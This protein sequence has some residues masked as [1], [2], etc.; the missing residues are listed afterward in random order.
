MFTDQLRSA[1]SPSH[2]HQT[3]RKW[4]TR[5]SQPELGL[6]DMLGNAMEWV[7]D[8]AVLY[9]TGQKDD[10]ENRKLLLIDERI[11][12]LLR[13]G[14]FLVQPV[15]LRSALRFNVRPGNRIVTV[16]FRPVRTLLH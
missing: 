14:S 11:S 15:F 6:F 2:L 16:G 12:R 5:R 1:N 8:P 4:P 13:G 3:D 7:E 9:V 10:I